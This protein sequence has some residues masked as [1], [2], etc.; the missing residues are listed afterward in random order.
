LPNASCIAPASKIA[1][2]YFSQLF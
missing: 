1:T 2:Y